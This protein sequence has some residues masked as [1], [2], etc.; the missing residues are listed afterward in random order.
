MDRSVKT[1]VTF[2]ATEPGPTDKSSGSNWYQHTDDSAASRTCVSSSGE[3]GHDS[4]GKPGEAMP[5]SRAKAIAL[6]I[7]LTGA[8]FIN[9]LSAQSVVIILPAMGKSLDI[10]DS[11]LQWIVSAYSLTFGCFLLLWG[12]IADIFGKRFIFIAGSIWVTLATALNPLM[13]NEISFDLFRGL[14]GLGAAA[15]VPTAIGILGVTFPPGKAKNYAFA[16]YGAGAPL[17]SI[18]G[19]ILSGVIAQ[20]ASWKWVFGCMA[21]MAAAISVAGFALVPHDPAL[22]KL[23]GGEEDTI[24]ARLRLVD[25]IGGALITV[26]LFALLFALTEGN[27]VGWQTAWVGCL[28]VI[29]VLL[30]VAFFFWQRHLEKRQRQGLG[31]GRPPLMKVSMFRSRQFTA[32]MAIM[33]LFFAS[34]NNFLVFATYYYQDYLGYDPLQTMLRFLP[35]GVGGIFVSFAVAFL[36]SRV[37]TAFMLICGTLSVSISNLLFAV[38]I[39]VTTSYFAWGMWAMLLSVVGADLT[40]PCLTFFTSQ[41][42]PAEDQ[43]IG[44]ALINAV[45]QMGRA[46]GLAIA[47]AVQTAVLAKQRGVSVEA[48]GPVREMDAASLASIRIASWFNFAI[49]IASLVIVCIAFRKMEVIGRIAP[50]APSSDGEEGVKN[51]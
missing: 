47:T 25:W 35:T 19:S 40:W 38:P 43:A 8:A 3:E 16:T 21:I 29:S 46:I 12:R 27:V 51:G 36:L 44:G 18:F 33:C 24:A 5:L 14:H 48:V 17:G 15:N 50:K 13:P 23:A 42:L 37:P 32:V 2:A 10:P 6:V 7:T 45:G 4:K 11:R 39:P 26:A 22:P 9:T 28:I 1:P 41:A 31:G 20:Y 49:G 30:L 34:F